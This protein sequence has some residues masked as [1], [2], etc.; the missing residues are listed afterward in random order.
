[1]SKDVKKV[2]RDKNVPWRIIEEEAVLVNVDGGEVI[3][4]NPTGAAIW[5]FIEEEKSSAEIVSYIC[6]EF[7]VD[8]AAARKDLEEFLQ[9]LTQKGVLKCTPAC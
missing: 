1:M 5:N 8:E 2:S 7:E 3:H 9:E 4:L 6:S